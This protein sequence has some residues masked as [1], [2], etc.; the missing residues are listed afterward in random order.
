MKIAVGGMIASGKSTLVKGLAKELGYDVLDEFRNDD[1]VFNTLL[2][3]LYEGKDDVEML[4]Q[5]YFL[6]KHYKTQLEK[7]Q[8]VV[9]DRH[10]IE[11]WLFA[12][13]N[14][15][16]KPEVLNFYNGLFHSYMNTVTQPDLYIILD[17]SWD[18][19]VRRIKKRGRAQEMDNIENNWNYFYNL[20]KTYKSKL[21]AQ[22][23]VYDIPYV[24][25]NDDFNTEED[26][27]REGLKLIRL[28]DILE[29]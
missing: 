9:V 17:I 23:K 3:W 19:F 13:E 27:V 16:H 2:R 25:L 14:L 12:Q 18:T 21:E 8:D 22:C 4:L 29:R 6:H 20:L 5:V 26:T 24:V 11:H 7:T 28:N 10:I 1:E 15:K